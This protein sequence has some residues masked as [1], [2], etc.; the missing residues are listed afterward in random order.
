MPFRVVFCRSGGH[1]IKRF[2][3]VFHWQICSQPIRSV[4]IS[5]AYKI[6]QWKTLTKRLMKCP[7]WCNLGVQMQLD[8]IRH[9][10]AILEVGG[11]WWVHTCVWVWAPPP[12]PAPPR[13]ITCRYWLCSHGLESRSERHFG[14]RSKTWLGSWFELRA[15][16]WIANAFPITI[17]IWALRDNNLLLLRS[18]RWLTHAWL[19]HGFSAHFQMHTHESRSERALRSHVLESGFLRESP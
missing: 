5:V 3:S 6:C 19:Q 14:S 2:V 4:R 10:G 7:P 13:L 11:C 8:A 16:T 1:F 15:F 12:H 9:L 17:R 18:P